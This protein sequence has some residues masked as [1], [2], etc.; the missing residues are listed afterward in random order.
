MGCTRSKLNKDICEKDETPEMHANYIKQYSLDSYYALMG[1]DNDKTH[2]K[3][4]DH[5][6]TVNLGLI[7]METKSETDTTYESSS[8]TTRDYIEIALAILIV[9]GAVRTLFRYLK[10]KKTKAAKRKKNQLKELVVE[11]TGPTQGMIIKPFQ[12]TLPMQ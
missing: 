9:L 12:K 1:V 3:M 7:N 8:F 4:D 10:K 5:S 2:T 6:S 11:A